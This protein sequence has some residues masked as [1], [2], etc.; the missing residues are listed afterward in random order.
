MASEY[1][2]L[3]IPNFAA[4]FPEV[5]VLVVRDDTKTADWQS[6]LIGLGFF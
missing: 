3:F 5:L 4:L 1:D 2:V 6:G